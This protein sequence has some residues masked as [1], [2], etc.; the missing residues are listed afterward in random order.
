MAKINSISKQ[1]VGKKLRRTNVAVL[2]NTDDL[3]MEQVG[4]FVNFLRDN[5]VLGLA[6]GFVAGSQ[7]QALV[8]QLIA[9]FIDPAF[10]LF[11]GMSLSSRELTL[12]F[13]AHTAQ[14][15]YGAFVYA[16]LNV[17][18]VLAA[19]YVIIKVFKL[20]RLNKVKEVIAES[21][22]KVEIVGVTKIK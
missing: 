7:A 10:Q 4:G 3:V 12:G 20:D 21:N 18:F 15:K 9:S 1:S 22:D 13:H 5:A 6:I 14:F 16:L 19:I 2:L 11:F 17:L 8:K